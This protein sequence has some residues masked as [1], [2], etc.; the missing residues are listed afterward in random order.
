MEFCLLGPVEAFSA[1]GPVQLGGVKPRALLA[2]LLLERGR[3]VPADRL[4]TVV[5]GEEPPNTARAVLQTYVATLRRALE[6]AGA[7][8]VIASDR[9]GYR[10]EV[11]DHAVDAVVFEG[12]VEQGRHA[13]LRGDHDEARGLLRTGLA[14]WR[15]PALGGIGESFLRAEAV[16]LDELRLTA[17]EER[18][19]ADLAV[20]QGPQQLAELT[21]LVT[22]HP[23]RER[24]RGGLMIALYRAG[25]QADALAVY[26][27]GREALADELGIDP[28]PELRRTHEAILRCDPSL[29]PAVTSRTPRQ[30]PSPPPDFTG[31]E[32]EIAALRAALV[33]PDTMP[34]GIVSGAGGMG[35]ST[36][37]HRVGHEIAEFFPDGQHH[38][39][40][41]GS[42]PTPATVEEVLGRVLRD[43]DP[44]ATPPASLEERVS[45]YRTLLAGTRTLVVLDDAAN[46][47]QVRPLLP[48]SPGCTVLITSR[49]RLTALAGATFAEL[50]VLPTD[51]A[52]DL[53][54]RIV[55]AER[56]AAEPEAAAEIIRLCGRLPLAIRI[57]GARLVSRRQ[58]TLS[59]MAS[60]LT[61]EQHRLDELTVGDQQVRASINLSYT[62]LPA[63]A[64]V[65][66]RR[67]GMLGL[68]YFSAWI[69]ASAL[70]TGLDE[71]EDV[72]EALVDVSL[73]D[74][75]GV[76]Q[77]GLMRYRLH[78]LVRLFAQERA[79]AEESS[80]DRAATMERVLGGWI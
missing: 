7:T 61:G 49:N 58:W 45:R 78:D 40:L 36:L 46:E 48:G 5:W 41:H 29:L 73:V 16:R 10:A 33:R 38:L 70:E 74:V 19:D 21:E 28:G 31:R 65:A 2:A 18:V 64:R 54:A 8:S 24:L 34:I 11:P 25:R 42:T 39:E 20:G 57:A 75:D 30:L 79:M 59:R 1:A 22:L 15:G 53:F 69:A 51:A 60:R 56:V 26:D 77:I 37:A 6:S 9:Q 4:M 67:L 66:L 80:K 47:A 23:T 72:L 55:G 14:L 35:K 63:P 50:E 76:D 44:A 71:A 62:L 32:P 43:L 27:Q 12:L 17:T 3:T 52:A 13:I 68:P